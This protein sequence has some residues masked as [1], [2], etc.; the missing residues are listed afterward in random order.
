MLNQ[1]KTSGQM[2]WNFK[3]GVLVAAVLL[4]AAQ[5][6]AQTQPVTLKELLKIALDENYTV[7]VSR[8]EEEV[9]DKQ[10]AETRARS[11]PQV[12]GNANLTDNYKRQVLV[13]PAELAGGDGS[14]GPAKIVAGTKFSSAM[15]VEVTQP[16]LDMAAFTGLKASKAG[17][18]YALI[19]T[20]QTKEQII[21]SVAAQYY[22]VLNNM[23]EVKLQQRTAK[24]LEQLIQ[25][26]E[27]QYNNGLL[28][29]V[30]LDRIRVNL[31]NT[32]SK[33]T[34]AQNEV[35]RNI[36][37]LKV[38]L[39]MPLNTVLVLDTLA[40]DEQA[41]PAA[42]QSA[43]FAVDNRTELQL[44]DSQIKLST[45]Q[46][47][48]IRAENYPKLNAFFNYSHNIMSDEFGAIFTNEAPAI[49]YGMGTWGVRLQVPIFSGFSRT[50]RVAQSN[51]K[52]QQLQKQREAKALEL[53]AANQNAHIQMNNTLTMLHAQQENVKLSEEVYASNRANYNLG[54]S[55][56]TDLLDSQ[57]AYLEAKNIY[58]KSI[59]NYKLAELEL[60][61]S[62]GTLLSLVN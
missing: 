45:L 30:D 29:K 52:I 13:L 20:R 25:A 47:N 14:G 62:N 46:R 8:L 49:T 21:N 6:M 56:L 41:L 18:E 10:I 35:D 40:M 22:Q 55:P 11:L 34:Q 37:Q 7:Q 36:N 2:K 32:Q 39:G 42:N 53:D 27:G 9:V 26:S 43:S 59:L 33:L 61:R 60:M 48:A 4:M 28:R 16:L 19:N 31:I 23:E 5:A 12:N 50:S 3:Q 15:G 57:T 58:T 54:L 38:Y 24:I 1:K 17:R 44:L 51:L